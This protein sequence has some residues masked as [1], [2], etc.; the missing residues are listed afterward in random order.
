LYDQ[1]IV[2][3]Y[4]NI[5]VNSPNLVVCVAN[6]V[7]NNTSYKLDL[8]G[9]YIATGYV[10]EFFYIDNGT[11]SL[12]TSPQRYN[13]YDLLLTDS[14]TFLFT[15]LDENGIEVPG[16]IVETLRYYIGEGVFT[17][18]ERSKE[19][20]NGETHIHLVEE[21]VI[22]KFRITLNNQ[23][24]FLSDQYNAKCLSSPCSITLS[25]EP[26]NEPF[27]TDNNN[28]PEGSYSVVANKATRQ[29]TLLFNLNQTET[30]NLSVWTQNNNEAELV[31]QGT[32]T[33]SSGSVIVSVPLQ[34]GN[35]T[36]SAVIYMNDDFVATRVVDLSEDAS[37]Y[38]GALGLFLAAL[39][40]LC[41]ALIGVS[42]GEWVIVWTV[43]GLVVVSLL[44]LV[45]LP[46]YALMTF[47]A[48]VG[49][50]LIKLVS[51]RRVN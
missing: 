26:E 10:Q 33:A 22:Y 16:V 35:A 23:Q 47:I 17:E 2:F 9:S 34:Y 5:T 41:L 51:R 20:D 11:I 3:S 29:V 38:F 50:F 30:M 19:D 12:A 27:P 14:T 21:D 1:D 46:W 49:V 42:H 25:A 44:Y 15:F 36:Y 6:G 37:N 32:T 28:L 39:A 40:V 13:W 4:S 48:G 18:V 31:A 45:D 24:I 8:T 43:I 7:L